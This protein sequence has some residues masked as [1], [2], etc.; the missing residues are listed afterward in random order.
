MPI[1]KAPVTS[2]VTPSIGEVQVEVPKL[3][4]PV[5]PKVEVPPQLNINKPTI[6]PLP[7]LTLPKVPPIAALG[8][9]GI[10]SGAGPSFGSKTIA[11]LSSFLQGI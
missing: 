8:E 4:A 3:Q 11:K 10:I 1:V 5:T 9:S 2:V 7:T 6:P